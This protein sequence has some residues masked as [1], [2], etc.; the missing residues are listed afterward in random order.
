MSE[1]AYLRLRYKLPDENQSR[2]LQQVVQRKDIQKNLAVSTDHFR[3]AASVAAFGQIMRG[4]KYTGEY[5]LDDVARLA[6]ESRGKDPHGYRSEFLSLVGLANT[7]S[8]S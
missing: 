7:L 5:R 1:L 4:G 6:R 2:L 3:F 8:G